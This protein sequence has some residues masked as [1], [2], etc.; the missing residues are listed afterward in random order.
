MSD[1]I[2]ERRRDFLK[3]SIA[4]AAAAP[5]GLYGLSSPVLAATTSKASGTLRAKLDSSLKVLDPIWTTSYSTRTHGFL[6]YDTLFGV[7]EHY[8][9]KPQMVDKYHVSDDHMSYRFTLRDGLKWHDGDPVTSDDCVASLKRWGARDSLGQKLMAA[10]GHLRVV[11]DKT[12]ELALKQ[13]FGLVLESLA[14]VSSNVP[15]MMKKAQAMTDPD[16]Q[17]SEVIGSGPFKFV[18]DK[19]RPGDRALYVKNDAYVPR[20]EPASN[21]AGGKVAHVDQVE[22]V[23][24]PDP[25]TAANAIMAGEIDFDQTPQPDLLPQLRQAKG[26][27]VEVFD[28]LGNQPLIRLNWLIPPFDN[29][30][31]RQAVLWA[32]N[33]KEEL[34]AA[35][36]NDP[37]MYRLCY[38]M[39]TCDGPLS[40]DA[41][42]QA[43]KQ[44]N[45]SKAKQLLKESGYN[46][47]KVV[48]LHATDDPII[49]AQTTVTE[50]TLRKIGMNIDVQAMD[51][52]TLVSRRDVKKPVS[53]GGWNL[54]Q[55]WFTGPAFLNPALH[56]AIAADGTK[57]WFGWPSDKEIE[58]LRSEFVREP[59]AEKRKEIARK[60]Q[61]RAYEVVTYVPLGTYFQPV[62]FRSDRVHGFVKSPVPLFWNV[63]KS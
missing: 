30:K 58:R 49:N 36:G 29:I 63:Q 25:S 31:A 4:A 8:N 59:N 28:K 14:K 44:Q 35:V 19:F 17:I 3:L 26:V 46:G 5:M 13:P 60:I 1:K 54:F 16:K 57:A 42:S 52:S 48:V 51:W 33:E 32:T 34:I 61:I 20:S 12:F 23:W 47:D 62:V 37:S 21:T 39:Y 53:Q 45:L 7:D 56:E 6:V 50:Q 55:T 27:K 43:L 40:T 15:F 10:T 11:D 2:D 24:I 41:G 9:V 38:S 22:I 18:K